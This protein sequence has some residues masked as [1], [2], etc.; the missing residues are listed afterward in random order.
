[1]T[2]PA[3]IIVA[4]FC[5]IAASVLY[6]VE[7]FD[8][9]W[10]VYERD[11]GGF[12]GGWYTPEDAV[13]KDQRWKGGKWDFEIV[14][15]DSFRVRQHVDP[16]IGYLIPIV[17]FCLAAFVTL[18]AGSARSSGWKLDDAAQPAAAPGGQASAPER[19]V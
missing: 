4:I 19:H 1:M 8:H 12:V 18:V 3:R 10:I 16:I 15:K 17:L 14:S 2:K 5:V 6:K 9:G 7:V 13:T 11:A